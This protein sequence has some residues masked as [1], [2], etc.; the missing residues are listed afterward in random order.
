MTVFMMT[1]TAQS[2]TP[3]PA[4][5]KP[6]AVE[7]RPGWQSDDHAEALETFRRSC[8]E[9]IAT[10]HGFKRAAVFGGQR[11]DWQH[12]CNEA[13]I[14]TDAKAFFATMFDAYQVTDS[15][16]PDGL[17]T[18]Y[19]EPQAEG[20]R[21][22]APGFN[23]PIYRKPDDLVSLAGPHDAGTSPAYGRLVGGKPQP[24]FTRREIEHGALAG[25]GLEIAWLKNW[26]DAFFIHIQGSGRIHL[27]DGSAI[28]LAYAAKTGLPYTAIGGVL[29]QRGILTRQTNSMQSIRNWM[30]N[31]PADARELMWQNKSF[32]FFREVDVADPALGALG[33]QQVNLTAR[34]SL[35]VDRSKWMLGTPVWL[36]TTPPPESTGGSQPFHHLMVAQD[37]GSA[38]KGSAR[39]DV[40]WGWGDEAARIAGHMKSHGTMIV[41][42][43][44]AVSSRL[45]LPR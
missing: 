2:E 18:G 31:N 3:V 40:Y 35:A 16:H 13:L 32:V 33:A 5:L 26:E 17:F 20:S 36:E 21:N 37:T 34:R 8:R 39:G 14:A 12:I 38:I 23:V 27:P 19:Y 42:L 24:Y 15:E 11:E 25:R 43:P 4:S 1:V 41:L 28:R 6:I 29:M 44:K 7:T 22:Q 30:K 10:G 45:K 9:I